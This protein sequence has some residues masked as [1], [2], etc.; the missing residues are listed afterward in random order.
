MHVIE[1]GIGEMIQPPDLDGFR[2]WNRDKKSRALAVVTTWAPSAGARSSL[3]A[4]TNA[5]LSSR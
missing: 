5:V 2:E 4:T 1:S 3:C